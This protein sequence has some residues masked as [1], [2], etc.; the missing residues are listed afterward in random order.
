MDVL[1]DEFYDARERDLKKRLKPKR[2]RHVQGVADT[3]ERLARLYGVD[4]RTARLAGL[5]HDWDKAYDDEQIRRRA[6]EFEVQVDPYVLDE[7]PRLLHGP[8][9]AAA[10]R[11]EW[12]DLPEE[13][14]QSI[15]RHTT[16]AVDM[17]DLDMVVYIADAI[18]PSRDFDG[19]PELREAVGKVSLEELFVRTFRHIFLMLVG[20]R[21]RLHPQTVEVWNHYITRA[22]AAAGKGGKA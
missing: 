6:I 5:L 10:L 4:A 14:L 18:E 20:R 2:F 13:V 8:T 19:V 15:E 16:G 1:S 12:P 22:R 3:A 9:A 21:K 11:R 17:S 7:M